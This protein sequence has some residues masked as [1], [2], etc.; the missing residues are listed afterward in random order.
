MQVE[1]KNIHLLVESLKYLPH[2]IKLL[3]VGVSEKTYWQ[4]IT[5]L[6]ENLK[7][8]DR[9]IYAGYTPYPETAIA[10]QASDLYVLPS[11]WEGMPKSIMESLA[12]GLP[13]IVSGFK[14]SE[15][16]QGLYYL[17]DISSQGIAS[18]VKELIDHPQPV[19]V[20][21]VSRFYSWHTRIAKIDEV[22]EF[23]KKNIH[24]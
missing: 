12:C 5:D 10:L 22:Y 21:K 18:K 14:A 24:V 4:K 13:T 19:D 23:A 9:V 1:R 11:K 16:I 8:K 17:D 6:I 3:L 7:I 20:A 2:N 15:D